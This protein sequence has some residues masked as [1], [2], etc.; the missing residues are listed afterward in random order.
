LKVSI[1]KLV[2]LIVK[3]VITALSCQGIEVD[4]SVA[5]KKNSSKELPANKTRLK[6]DMSGYKTPVLTEN[7]LNSIDPGITE[8][9]VPEKTVITPGAKIIIK[10]KQLIVTYSNKNKGE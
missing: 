9:I 4:L 2:E 7:H 5:E 1:E 6:I 10:T 3:E 8:I